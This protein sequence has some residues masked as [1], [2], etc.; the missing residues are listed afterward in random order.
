MLTTPRPA[1]EIAVLFALFRFQK[2]DTERVGRVFG[3]VM[4]LWF[5]VV[6]IVGV[7]QIAQR[8]VSWQRGLRTYTC[9]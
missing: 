4:V 8:R 6:A 2:G 1:T 9:Q 7:L 3:R 5:G